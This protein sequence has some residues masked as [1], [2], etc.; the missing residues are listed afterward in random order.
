MKTKQYEQE[1]N[2]RP[3]GYP[4][5]ST[6]VPR[7]PPPPLTHTWG[8][9]CS[10]NTQF[11]NVNLLK[12]INILTFMVLIIGFQPFCLLFKINPFNPH[13]ASFRIY[14]E[15]LNFLKPG[16]SVMTIFCGTIR[17]TTTYFVA[18]RFK[19]FLFTTS[20]ELRQRFMACT[21]WRW[22]WNF[23]E[24]WAMKLLAWHNILIPVVQILS[25]FYP[26]E[27]VLRGIETQLQIG[28]KINSV[29]VEF[30]AWCFLN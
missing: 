19:S 29:A 11:I 10:S 23:K 30:Y 6:N 2:R 4:L 17:I 16:G 13:D 15:W 22:Q 20:R 21:G 1:L 18:T 5:R 24:K 8:R 27:A 3:L 14:E 7:P 12:W 26:H 9:N 25:V 28:K